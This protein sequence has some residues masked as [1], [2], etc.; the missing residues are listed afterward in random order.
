MYYFDQNGFIL[1]GRQSKI[2]NAVVNSSLVDGNTWFSGDEDGSI[3]IYT[4]QVWLIVK[5][6]LY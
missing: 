2:F 4:Y 5:N 3:R 6:K 1:L